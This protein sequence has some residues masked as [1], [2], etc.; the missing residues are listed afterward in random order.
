ML[1]TKCLQALEAFFVADIV[2]RNAA[3]VADHLRHHGLYHKPEKFAQRF[4]AGA[5][6][7]A[8]VGAT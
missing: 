6:Q 2:L 7:F 3:S 1:R 5:E 8:V 4:Q